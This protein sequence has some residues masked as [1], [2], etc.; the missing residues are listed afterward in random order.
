M[1][2]LKKIISNMQKTL[3]VRE[4]ARTTARGVRFALNCPLVKCVQE[5]YCLFKKSCPILYS[6]LQLPKL[7]PRNSSLKSV[8]DV[9][10][11]KEE[12]E[13]LAFTTPAAPDPVLSPDLCQNSGA[14]NGYPALNPYTQFRSP[15]HIK[16]VRRKKTYFFIANR[17]SFTSKTCLSS[18]RGSLIIILT[19]LHISLLD[20]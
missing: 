4:R 5:G 15:R 14:L 3:R 7:S 16:I 1:I 10:V 19:N 20:H 17:I 8:Q 12:H 6:K 13:C 11:Q 2:I 9:P 18:L